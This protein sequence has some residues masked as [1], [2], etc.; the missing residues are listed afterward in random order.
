MATDFDV[1]PHASDTCDDVP[2]DEAGGDITLSAVATMIEPSKT[3]DYPQI[4]TEHSV[5]F[6]MSSTSTMKDYV[7][8]IERDPDGWYAAV[9]NDKASDKSFNRRRTAMSKALELPRVRTDVGEQVATRVQSKLRQAWKRNK[10]VY[11][12]DARRRKAEPTAPCIVVPTTEE[13]EPDPDDDRLSWGHDTEADQAEDATA[14]AGIS[15]EPQGCID[16][17]TFVAERAVEETDACAIKKKKRR[18]ARDDLIDELQH[19]NAALRRETM[20][21]DQTINRILSRLDAQ[22]LS[23]DGLSSRLDGQSTRMDGICSRLDGHSLELTRR[24][25]S[26]PMF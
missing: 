16:V 15:Y 1:P 25:R 14:D 7:A 3:D 5:T 9:P 23:I 13:D 26:R 6:G 4:F 19:E 22:Q 2:V 18:V 11:I 8:A 17:D 20:E 24:M 10:D 12:A 21:L